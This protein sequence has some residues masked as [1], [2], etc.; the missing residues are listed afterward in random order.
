M[1]IPKIQTDSKEDIQFLINQ[2]QNAANDAT[3]Q[4]FANNST[5]EHTQSQVRKLMNQVSSSMHHSRPLHSHPPHSTVASFQ[6]IKDIFEL[7]SSSIEVN[8][9]DYHEAFQNQDGKNIQKKKK[10]TPLGKRQG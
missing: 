5:D 4:H 8:G 6:W 9:L 7:A 3:L 10:N 1:D 2:L